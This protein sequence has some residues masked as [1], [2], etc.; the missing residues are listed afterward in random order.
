MEAFVQEIIALVLLPALALGVRWVVRDLIAWYERRPAAEQEL[1]RAAVRAG[2]YAA[3]Q[4]G[5]TRL[6]GEKR[7][8]ALET[9]DRLLQRQGIHVHVADLTALIEATVYDEIN[10]YRPGPKG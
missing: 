3:E 10:R 5:R 9:A 7:Q 6:V 8:F 4:L 2:V 1:I